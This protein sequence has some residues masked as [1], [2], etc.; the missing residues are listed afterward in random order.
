MSQSIFSEN[1]VQVGEL[2]EPVGEGGVDRKRAHRDGLPA[3]RGRFLRYFV[4]GLATLALLGFLSFSRWLDSKRDVPDTTI[5]LLT[6]I[7]AVEVQTPPPPPPPDPLPPPPK[8]PPLPKLEI[9]INSPAPPVKATTN[10]NIRPSITMANF[11]TNQ[12]QERK[13]MTFSLKDLDGQ[14]RLLN[15]PHITFPESLRERGIQEGRVSLEVIINPD[16]QVDVLRVIESS[17]P[18]F[19]TL[20]TDIASRARFSPPKKDGRPV[21]ARFQWPLI[22]R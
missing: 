10:P 16:G 15:R 19:A 8:T 12:P 3:P 4:S 17:E 13:R 22:I 7:D 6:G 21:A 20:A 18:E 11:S 1:T 9:Q 2:I 5:R 14:P